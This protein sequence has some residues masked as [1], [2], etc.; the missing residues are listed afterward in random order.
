ML[1]ATEHEK[2]KQNQ[3]SLIASIT[4]IHGMK[5]R[6]MYNA[7]VRNDEMKNNNIEFLVQ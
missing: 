7:T 6:N 5:V 1:E 4:E 3:W 2:E